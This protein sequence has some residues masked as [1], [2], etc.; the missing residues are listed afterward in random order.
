[1]LA[2]SWR[3]PSEC[4]LRAAHFRDVS[5]FLTCVTNGCDKTTFRCQMR[6][7]TPVA[8]HSCRL[9]GWALSTS[10]PLSVGSVVYLRRRCTCRW[11]VL[12]LPC[13]FLRRFD[14]LGEFQGLVKIE[15][16]FCEQPIRDSFMVH[17]ASPEACPATYLCIR[18]A[19][20]CLVA[21]QRSCQPTPHRFVYEY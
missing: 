6:S 19:V 8:C 15:F 18:N 21:P 7:A 17:A 1:M 12:D 5:T 10:A 20:R 11:R 2:S 3:H 16:P 9:P 14:G 4:H 13:V